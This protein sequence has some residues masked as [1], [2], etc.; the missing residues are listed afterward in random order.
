M[1]WKHSF[2]TVVILIGVIPLFG[3]QALDILRIRNSPGIRS[4]L[5]GEVLEV[6]VFTT[7]YVARTEQCSG[8]VS[9]LRDRLEITSK[10]CKSGFS[11]EKEAY[12]EEIPDFPE[13]SPSEQS[14]SP[15]AQGLG[16]GLSPLDQIFGSDLSPS[17]GRVAPGGIEIIRTYHPNGNIDTESEYQ[18]EV[19]HGQVKYYDNSGKILYSET[20]V[21][22]LR[23]GKMKYYAGNGE[24]IRTEIIH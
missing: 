21:N 10:L 22:G 4:A 19:L 16:L 12:L 8:W 15:L 9:V 13:T 6:S 5:Q 7:Q 20:Y 1:N 3:E 23:K 24:L 14:N 2:Y 17:G 11:A 18:N